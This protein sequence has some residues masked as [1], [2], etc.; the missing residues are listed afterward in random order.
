MSKINL[1]LSISYPIIERRISKVPLIGYRAWNLKS[2]KLASLTADHTID[3]PIC[4]N[5]KPPVIMWKG[6]LSATARSL[7][8]TYD[9]QKQYVGFFCYKNPAMAMKYLDW[10]Y[11]AW[12]R[13]SLFG[14]VVEHELGYRAQSIRVDKIF[15]SDRKL[16]TKHRD[17]LE[18]R[19]QCDVV[20]IDLMAALE[21]D[22]NKL[23]Q[24]YGV[25][26]DL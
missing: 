6:F 5:S 15:T 11:D 23:L 9:E 19:Y 3:G 1:D 20:L 12:T 2:G 22:F 13:V 8:M 14:T 16:W 24:T 10:D 25:S 17:S 4:S 7:E 21:D 26:D 18:S